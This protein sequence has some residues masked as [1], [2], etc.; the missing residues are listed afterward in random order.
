MNEKDN[1]SMKEASYYKKLN[2]IIVQCQLCP[3]FCTIK[4]G[5]RG[6]CE[7]RENQKGILYSLVYGKACSADCDPIEKKPLYHFLPGEQAMSLA[8][9]G[10]NLHCKQC[11]N[12]QISQTK[13]EYYPY[14]SLTPEEVVEK[15]REAECR[16]IAYTY[17]EPTIFYEY[18]LD[19]AKIAK[20]HGLKNVIVSNGF[21]NP[22]PLKEL[23]KYIDGANID[24]KS[25]SEG[26]YNEIC[27]GRLEPVLKAIEILHEN[28]VWVEITNLIIP[29][30][31]DK[32]PEIRKLAE[33]V[34]ELDADIPLHFSAFYPTYK[35]QDITPTPDSILKKARK[36]ALKAGLKYVYTG[37]ID[38][39]EGSATFCPKCKKAVIKRRGFSVFEINIEKGK[40]KFCGAKILGI[41]S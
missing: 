36:I 9:I 19:T 6:K 29:T 26:F 27:D 39:D 32:E 4:D 17:T 16:I 31:N 18:M 3:H 35:L 34:K 33:W 11:Q 22:E 25:F 37:N 23:C 5:E 38:D 40:C 10:C 21:I 24:L 7:T 28:N 8:T 14:I 15:T 1:S 30:L 12:W 41:W 13:P 2:G 20:K